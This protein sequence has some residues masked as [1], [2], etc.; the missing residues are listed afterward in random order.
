[1]CDNGVRADR[2]NHRLLKRMKEVGFRMLG[3]GIESASQKVLNNIKKSEKIEDMRRAVDTA[4]KLGYKVELFFLIGSPGETWDDFTESVK[5]ATEFPISIASF[6]QLL[7]YPG[8]ELFDYV[9]KNHYLITTPDRYLN[10]G[11]QR[12]NTPFFRTP[13]FTY[14]DR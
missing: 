2:V 7:P 12:K 10:T 14:A 1:M 3:F 11:S 5:F 8:T 13:D 9:S 4:C 6:Y